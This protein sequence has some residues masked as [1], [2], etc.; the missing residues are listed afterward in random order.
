M[1][2]INPESTETFGFQLGQKLNGGDIVALHGDLGSGKT[3]LARGIARGLGVTEP[4]A[5]PTYTIVQEY[6]GRQWALYHIDMYRIDTVEAAEAF[7]LEYY[8]SDQSAIVVVEW[9]ERIAPLLADENVIRVYL[10]HVEQDVRKI[11]MVTIPASGA[12]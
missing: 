2:S 7:G 11:E 5:S 3:V 9:A 1:V 8:L 10:S 12:E 4:V 6:T